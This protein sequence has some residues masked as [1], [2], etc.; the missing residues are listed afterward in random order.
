MY[1]IY[2]YT[3]YIYIYIIYNI[4]I[5]YIYIYIYI[6]TAFKNIYTVYRVTLKKKIIAKQIFVELVF[7]IKCSKI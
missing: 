3:L 2:I 5:S 6:Y 4:C 1:I 7:P